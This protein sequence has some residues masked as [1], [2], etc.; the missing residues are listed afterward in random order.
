MIMDK[1]F[2][3]TDLVCEFMQQVV[4]FM[5]AKT[6]SQRKEPCH[7]LPKGVAH[8]LWV[9]TP[10]GGCTDGVCEETLVAS[11]GLSPG[12][13]EVSIVKVGGFMSHSIL[14]Y[15]SEKEEV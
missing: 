9:I 10:D 1:L 8:V 6:M 14:E 7:S 3:C 4:I 13:H 12:N 15:M 2:S 5:E 11:K